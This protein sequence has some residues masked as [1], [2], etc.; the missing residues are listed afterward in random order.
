MGK[1]ILND[2]VIDEDRV[3]YY[4]T[5]FLTLRMKDAFYLSWVCQIFLI[6]NQVFG[7]MFA[8]QRV[9]IVRVAVLSSCLVADIITGV[10]LLSRT[11]NSAVNVYFKICFIIVYS[12]TLRK[13][14][15]KL[16]RSL[17]ETFPAIVIMLLNL[18]VFSG[19]AFILFY[20]KTILPR[21]P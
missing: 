12:Q 14:M 21:H 2:C 5:K 20:G 15:V 18:V 1:D 11:I 19:I 9:Y 10:L 7:L 13:A 4:T 6:A 16:V 3:E 8:T 17:K